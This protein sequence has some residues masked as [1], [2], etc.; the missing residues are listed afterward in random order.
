MCEISYAAK[1]AL[2][3][4]RQMSPT[5]YHFCVIDADYESH[6]SLGL[7][8]EVHNWRGGASRDCDSQAIKFASL[9]Y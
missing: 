9:V 3:V 6:D 5:D 1:D 8:F 2:N 7:V 4:L